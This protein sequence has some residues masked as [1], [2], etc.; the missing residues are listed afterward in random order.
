[1]DAHAALDSLM[2]LWKE[3]VLSR[4]QVIAYLKEL[5]ESKLEQSPGYV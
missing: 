3:D 5:M 2:V 4:D 1:M